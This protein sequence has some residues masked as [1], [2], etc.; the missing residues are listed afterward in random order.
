[1]D[2][3][4]NHE[5]QNQGIIGK[6]DLSGRARTK[7]IPHRGEADRGEME[8][9]GSTFRG[10]GKLKKALRCICEFRILEK[11][12]PWGLRGYRGLDGGGGRT[13][14]GPQETWKKNSELICRT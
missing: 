3:A 8:G 7:R 14:I 5:R 11:G 13:D 4:M 12:L 2:G 10:G 6:K 9:R 1:M